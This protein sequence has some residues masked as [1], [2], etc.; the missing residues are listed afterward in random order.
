MRAFVDFCKQ[1]EGIGAVIEE[2][3]EAR[4]WDKLMFI[5]A[6]TGTSAV[7][8]ASCAGMKMVGG[9]KEDTNRQVLQL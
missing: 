6:F 3:I 2:D 5:T 1:C 4:M 8:R 7:T 9:G